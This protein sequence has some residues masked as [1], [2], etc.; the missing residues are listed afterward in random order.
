MDTKRHAKRT[1]NIPYIR[2][3]RLILWCSILTRFILTTTA[4]AHILP[5]PQITA[6]FNCARG[7]EGAVVGMNFP[8]QSSATVSINAQPAGLISTETDGGLYF[9]IAIPAFTISDTYTVAVSTAIT[10]TTHVVTDTFQVNDGG[11][12]CAVARGID[13][14]GN[15]IEPQTIE[16]PAFAYRQFVPLVQR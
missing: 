14:N 6:S 12:A 1:R 7:S 13:E 2:I 5:S 10:A 16:M 4:T 3:V 11:A 9:I 8:G 15:I